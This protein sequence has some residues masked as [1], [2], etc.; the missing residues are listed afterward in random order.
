[1]GAW[2]SDAYMHNQSDLLCMYDPFVG[3]FRF[4]HYLYVF[5]CSVLVHAAT[6]TRS[7]STSTTTAPYRSTP[8]ITYAWPCPKNQV[9]QFVWTKFQRD[10]PPRI[11]APW[12]GASKFHPIQRSDIKLG[13]LNL[14]VTQDKWLNF[15][16]SK[17]AVTRDW[18][19][20]RACTV[21][22]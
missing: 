2:D 9:R 13:S 12:S 5:G 20:G 14:T 21:P 18:W 22:S 10:I 8:F 6:R 19:M 17:G 1:M 7:L 4:L 15:I 11:C 3:I 16:S